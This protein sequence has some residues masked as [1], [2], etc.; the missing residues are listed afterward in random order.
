MCGLGV[1]VLSNGFSVDSVWVIVI[2]IIIKFDN[3]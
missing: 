2:C 3:Y 1:K